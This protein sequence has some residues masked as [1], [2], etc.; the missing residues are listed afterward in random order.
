MDSF[1]GAPSDTG[2]AAVA[3]QV[4]AHIP[5]INARGRPCAALAR[6]LVDDN[7]GAKWGKRV[8]VVVV[9]AI[10][11]GPSRQFGIEP[12]G[13]EQ[14]ESENCLRKQQA[15]M[16]ERKVGVTATEAGNEVVLEG[17]NGAFCG[18]P[19][20]DVGRSELVGNIFILKES[21]ERAGAFIV[22]GLQPRAAAGADE[23]VVEFGVG[24]YDDFGLATGNGFNSNEVAIVVI[25][26]QDVVV[27]LAG[28]KGEAASRITIAATC[29]GAVKDFG[30]EEVGPFALVI[31]RRKEIRLRKKGQGR[32][33]GLSRLNV[34]AGL[35]DVGLEGGHRIRRVLAERS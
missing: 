11:L 22:K 2:V 33:G 17:L 28:R 12:R 30:K 19:A 15:P 4:G 25:E 34:L 29:G 32:I 35:L 21:F 13:A 18:I 1:A 5:T 20:V 9:G 6:F 23:N 27:A 10:E 3:L 26:E 16:V 24:S 7:M 14:I 31:G 8:F